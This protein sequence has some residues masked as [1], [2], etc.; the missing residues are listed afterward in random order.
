MDFVIEKM[1]FDYLAV[2]HGRISDFRDDFKVWKQ[3]YEESIE[4]DFESIRPVL[5]KECDYML[6]IGGGLSGIT[7]RIYKDYE[8]LGIGPQAYILDGKADPPVARGPG[9]TFNNAT[10]T[11][12]FLRRNG[13]RRQAFLTPNDDLPR[14]VD[15][16]L[17]IQAWGFHF[18]PELYAARVAG[19]LAAK[20]VV[21]MDLRNAKPAWFDT[22][23]E[24]FGPSSRALLTAAKW[25]RWAFSR[26]PV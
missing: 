8:R 7:A 13:V 22:C 21:V 11:Q 6:D 4:G 24:H 19:A 15:L 12:N 2:Q 9:L 16:V 26:Y 23:V 1:H 18:A 10:M 3:K 17:S 5:P 20:G 25:T 14:R